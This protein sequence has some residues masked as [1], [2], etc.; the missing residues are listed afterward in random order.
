MSRGLNSKTVS[1][2]R[3]WDWFA[4]GLLLLA[5]LTASRRLM[6]TEW[7][8]DLSH[9]QNLTLIGT[10]L[11][12]AIGYSRFKGRTGFNLGLFYGLIA[13]PWQLGLTV[14]DKVEWSERLLS[15]LGRLMVTIDQIGR[16][17]NVTDPLLFLILMSVLYWILSTTAGYSLTRTGNP[18]RAVL[19][20]G[21][22]IV[23]IHTYDSFIS[24]RMWYL[25]FFLL[26]SLLL[27]AR[28]YYLSRRSSWQ[29]QHTHTPLYVGIDLMRVTVGA[30]V[31]LIL[32]AW[33]TPVVA[34]SLGPAA[35][36]WN[37]LTEPWLEIREE[38]GRAFTSLQA[39]VGIISDYYGKNLPLGRGNTL[40][41]MVVL[42]IETPLRQSSNIRFYWRA[43]VYDNYD[44]GQWS[45]TFP[46]IPK[47]F[48]PDQTDFSHPDYQGRWDTVFT[49]TTETPLS[50]LYT[51]SQ[52]T[53]VSR[54]AELQV[55]YNPDGNLDV[56]SIRA[57]VP[58]MA[59][60]T[61]QFFASVTDAT[62]SQ[63]RQAGNNYPEWVT[64]R[65]LQI[66][67]SVTP[68]TI[69]LAHEISEGLDN[70]YEIAEA[71]TKY[72]RE[73]ITYTDTVPPLPVNQDPIDWI[74]FEQNEGFCNYY[75]TSEV[76]LLRA[77]GIPAR[78]A[79]GYA[80]GER[81][82]GIQ[83]ELVSESIN[84]R[85]REGF[86]TQRF[87]E[88]GIFSSETYTVRQRDAHAWPEVYFPE[89]G[90]VEFEPTLNQLPLARL[91]GGRLTNSQDGGENELVG[92]END[93]SRDNN[94]LDDR[95]N[96]TPED[97]KLDTQD[98][99]G[100]SVIRVLTMMAGVFI[101]GMA[102][103]W[104]VMRRRGLQPISVLVETGFLKLNFEPPRIVIRWARQANLPPLAKAYMEINRAL[105]RLGHPAEINATPAERAAQLAALL[106][107]LEKPVQNLRDEYHISAYGPEEGNLK[108]A[109]EAS[110]AIKNNSYWSWFR[111]LL[112]RFQKP[113]D[114][115]GDLTTLILQD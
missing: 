8:Q 15:L 29:R 9:I 71:V 44:E 84:A 87:A 115:R 82:L 55:Q 42:T 78:M 28:I 27:V 59:G 37:K 92:R 19:P 48:T 102:I 39:S 112:A 38:I 75:A 45:T 35:R 72:L 95:E 103:F 109:K 101:I 94:I 24:I 21:V 47:F 73:N 85:M 70:P 51:A 69:E 113:E 111:E 31:I 53:W 100:N 64:D 52:P 107:T 41:D 76:I 25:A 89:I 105:K 79:V 26:C 3:L 60:E 50:I 33:V 2:G 104:R 97:T 30:T 63:L 34:S 90:W 62:V 54:P 88:E 40:T 46:E 81:T 106:P 98:S 77:L 61:Y 14:S 74:L 67:D 57:D 80:Q 49:V 36:I 91:E 110:R 22:A 32:L 108:I 66:P 93:P 1:S 16:E 4:A 58:V 114:D 96:L 7:T 18:W 13:I 56:A 6:A 23:I 65:Y 5:T 12:L 11:G 99:T 10:I 68:R 17:R 20:S 43:R 86:Q 83:E